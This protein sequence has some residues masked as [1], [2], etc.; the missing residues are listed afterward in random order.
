[1]SGNSVRRKTKSLFGGQYDSNLYFDLDSDHDAYE[2]TVSSDEIGTF[3]PWERL[4]CDE[5]IL[6]IY[7]YKN[8]LFPMQITQWRLFHSFIVFETDFAWW[9]IEK[10]S[11][12]VTIQRRRQKD[13]VRN[14]Y[15]GN[16]RTG[17]SQGV[18]PP[19]ILKDAV[20]DDRTT[21]RSLMQFMSECELVSRKYHFLRHNC[22]DFTCALFNHF[23][24]N[25]AWESGDAYYKIKRL[26]C[27]DDAANETG[28]YE[29]GEGHIVQ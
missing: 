17:Y 29:Y 26:S 16:L 11:D 12:G 3:N 15:R 27:S 2:V 24:R 14:F 19:H 10:N 18:S 25:K 13:T 1:M 22:K 23:A 20:K 7:L 6:A 28:S 4:E 5:H 9:S 21:I 8:K